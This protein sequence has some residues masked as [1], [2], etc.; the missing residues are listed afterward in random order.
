MKNYL[1]Q[2]LRLTVLVFLLLA[3]LSLLPENL[4]IGGVA[5]RRMDVFADIRAS[6]RDT[7]PQDP[8][9]QAIAPPMD[10]TEVPDS[11]LD[12]LGYVRAV[13]PD[14]FGQI[15][16]DYTPEQTGMDR[17]FAA[18]DAIRTQRRAVRIAF[19]GDSFVEGDILLGDLRDTLQTRWG[20]AGVGYV[21][22]TSE[23]ARFKRTLVHRYENWRTFSIVKNS[24]SGEPFG[25][26][27]FVY[28][29]KPQ[30]FVH[31]EGADYFKHT[32]RWTH[33]RLFYHADTVAQFVWQNQS[34]FPRYDSLPTSDGA[35]SIWSWKQSEPA[36]RA[37]ALRFDAPDSTLILYGA[38]LESGPGVYV[39]NFSVRGNTGG[40]L[41]L[42]QPGLARQF[43]AAQQYEL[44]VVQLGLNAV[45]P[46]LDN[47]RWYEA[48]LDQTYAHLRKCFSGK[49]ILAISVADRAGKIQGELATYPSVVAITEMQR[50]LA[51]KHGFLFFDLFHGMGGPGTMVEFAEHRR[52]ALANRDYTHLTHEGGKV[53]GHMFAQLLLD[54]QEEYKTRKATRHSK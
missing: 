36:T 49:L 38:S 23:V 14:L 10:T 29:P 20:G 5:L 33:F 39:D 51:R 37:F 16:E 40:R 35:L 47:L 1:D 17:F 45:T 3:G 7:V 9:G 19:F 31:Y 22:I 11:G 41:K 15:I 32:G 34:S 30:A 13:S 53:M 52:P 50:A 28:R 2:T 21:P 44:I 18:V 54:A 42:I 4:S 43:D 25:I 12:S 48:E 8:P 26:N 6:N 24:R 46:K 27:G